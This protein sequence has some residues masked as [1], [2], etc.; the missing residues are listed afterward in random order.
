MNKYIQKGFT[1]IEILIVITIIGVLVGFLLP[2]LTGIGGKTN[3]IARKKLLGEVVSNVEMYYLEE[4]TYPEG[5]FCIDG[6]ENATASEVALLAYSGNVAPTQEFSGTVEAYCDG[7]EENVYYQALEDS[8]NGNYAVF[9]LAEDSANHDYEFKAG[10]IV[11]T[12]QADGE[13]L[14]VANPDG[15]NVMAIIK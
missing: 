7:N 9:M 6:D 5:I 11:T 1:L 13:V 10:S 12:T 15:V 4:G 8:A 3:D 2:N 14:N